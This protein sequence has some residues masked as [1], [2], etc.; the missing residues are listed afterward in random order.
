M[1]LEELKIE[2]GKYGYKLVKKQEPILIVP[3]PI[4]GCIKTEEWHVGG[5]N[6]QRKCKSCNFKGYAR[7]SKAGAK[8]GWNDAVNDFKNNQMKIN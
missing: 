7:P 8:R 4:C 5:A 3:C 2:A 6:I 1:T